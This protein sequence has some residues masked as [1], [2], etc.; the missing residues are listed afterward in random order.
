MLSE[1]VLALIWVLCKLF[2][3]MFTIVLVWYGHFL[4]EVNPSFGCCMNIFCR[5]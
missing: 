2:L 3:Q 4:E 5:C 1:I